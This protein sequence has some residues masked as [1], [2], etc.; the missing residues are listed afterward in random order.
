MK[1]LLVGENKLLERKLFF[2][3]DCIFKKSKNLEKDIKFFKPDIIYFFD[4]EY[5]Y[6]P[7]IYTVFITTKKLEGK[8]KDLICFI[9]PL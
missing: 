1:I 2:V 8:E 4:Q 3:K 5:K 7:K 9:K 6:L